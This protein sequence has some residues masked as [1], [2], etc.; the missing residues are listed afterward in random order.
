MISYL[1][2]KLAWEDY[3]LRDL[4]RYFVDVGISGLGQGQMRPWQ[5]DIYSEL[6]RNS[7]VSGLLVSGIDNYWNEWLITFS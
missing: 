4:A 2:Q 7:V 5:A 3:S 6:I 1:L